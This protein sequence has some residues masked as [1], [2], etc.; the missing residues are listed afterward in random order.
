[1]VRRP[2]QPSAFG[3]VIV[4]LA[5]AA[6][7]PSAAARPGDFWRYL[8]CEGDAEWSSFRQGV[9]RFREA[10]FPPHTYLAEEANELLGRRG[11][12]VDPVRFA[13]ALADARVE[14]RP[15]DCVYGLF[16]AF[17]VRGREFLAIGDPDSARMDFEM[18]LRFLGRELGLDFLESTGWGLRSADLLL[19]FPREAPGEE[20]VS[21]EVR[22]A[23][24]LAPPGPAV[25][26]A[27][28]RA[29]GQGRG[30][31]LRLAAVWGTSEAMAAAGARHD[32]QRHGL[33]LPPGAYRAHL[34]ADT[35]CGTVGEDISGLV[36]RAAE[37]LHVLRANV[38]RR[39][40]PHRE[41]TR[42][43]QSAFFGVQVGGGRA[44]G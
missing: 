6:L 22:P 1:M 11:N 5:A 4:L 34:C 25:P 14:R 20:G 3:L 44:G 16:A 35:G 8:D 37:R 10:G 9:A 31:P 13:T 23:A 7:Q 33:W 29:E 42:G 12:E 27:A 36:R 2:T 19:A 41:G 17:F 32:H 30:P 24:E 38:Q 26:A 21:A 40:P 43:W 15:Q 18:A 39:D 28:P